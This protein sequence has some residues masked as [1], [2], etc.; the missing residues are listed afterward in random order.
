ML[1]IDHP[2][3]RSGLEQLFACTQKANAG[4]A[5]GGLVGRAKQAFWAAAGALTFVK[6]YFIPV[7]LHALPNTVK[8]VPAW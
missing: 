6:M 7:K 3:F 5:A 4:R 1:D 2:A 8:M